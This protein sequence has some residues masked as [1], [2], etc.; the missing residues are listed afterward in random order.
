M[1]SPTGFLPWGARASWCR[2][3]RGGQVLK[4]NRADHG[5]IALSLMRFVLKK[6][7]T[8]YSNLPGPVPKS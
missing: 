1:S 8:I 3:S 6:L 7:L 4:R 2:R 5:H